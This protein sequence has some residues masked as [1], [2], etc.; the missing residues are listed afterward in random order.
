MRRFYMGAVLMLFIWPPALPPV[1][2]TTCVQAATDTPINFSFQG[3]LCYEVQ[4]AASQDIMVMMIETDALDNLTMSFADSP[5]AALTEINTSRMYILKFDNADDEVEQIERAKFGLA[6]PGAANGNIQ[7]LTYTE[8]NSNT[9]TEGSGGLGTSFAGSNILRIQL[10]AYEFI[11]IPMFVTCQ[12]DVTA[13]ITIANMADPKDAGFLTD[14]PRPRQDETVWRDGTLDYIIYYS[15][16]DVEREHNFI[17]YLFNSQNIQ[18]DWIVTIPEVECREALDPQPASGASITASNVTQVQ[19][20]VRL[21][22]HTAGVTGVAFS[23]DGRTAI[24]GS[25]DTTLILWDIASGSI[26]RQFVGHGQPVEAVAFAPDGQTVLSGGYDNQLILWDVNTGQIIRRYSAHTA[27]VESVAYSPDG[28]QLLSGSSDFTMILWDTNTGQIVRQFTGHS[29]VVEGVAYS[30]GGQR[31][32]SASLD[33]TAR[34]W[35]A[36]SGQ[37]LYELTAHNG[38]VESAAFS[39]NGAQFVTSSADHTLILWDTQTGNMLRQYVGH[40]DQVESVAFSPDGT[41][42]ASSS[43]DKT[44]IIWSVNDSRPLKVL[45]GHTER[46]DSLDFSNDGRFIISASIDGTVRVWGI[47]P[48]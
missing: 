15:A 41:L 19:E 40:T 20:L 18:Q 25:D 23:P 8:A 6:S 10:P 29:N 2:P 9:G 31:L 33:G 35:D 46:I 11:A 30:P 17:V 4:T 3:A 12:G 43:Q 28:R 1:Q 16:A 32:V 27:L 7:F 39:P 13:K 22:R 47:D 44:I 26:I 14:S 48:P 37:L 45:S 36:T 34:M 42:F 24:S 38:E 21:T 5:D